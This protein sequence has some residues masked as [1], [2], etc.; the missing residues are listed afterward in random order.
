MIALAEAAVLTVSMVGGYI[1]LHRRFMDGPADEPWPGM[2]W[3]QWNTAETP[4]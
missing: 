1:A 4:F 2:T 3:E